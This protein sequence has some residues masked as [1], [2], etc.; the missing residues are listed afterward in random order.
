ML[1]E[2]EQEVREVAREFLE[3]GG[4]TVLEARDGAGRFAHRR[5]STMAPIDLLVTDMVMPGM[6]GQ[7][8]AT[9]IVEK[10]PG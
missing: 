10:R 6:S 5:L 2:D 1:A 3:S 4:Y 9:R 8:L 7:E